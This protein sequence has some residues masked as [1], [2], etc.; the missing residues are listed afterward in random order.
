MVVLKKGVLKMSELICNECGKKLGGVSVFEFEGHTYCES[1]FIDLTVVCECCGDR[2]WRDSA[3]GDSFIVLCPHC[4]A[5]SYT[6]CER[7]S[8][9]ISNDSACYEDDYPYCRECYERILSKPIKSY[10]YK[11][12]PIFYGLGPRYYGLEIEVDCGGESDENAQKLLDYINRD[13][14][15]MYAKHDGSLLR[16]FEFV[17]HPMSLDHHLNEVDYEGLFH[18]AILM[19]Y[20][21]HMTPETAGIHVHINRDAFGKTIEE[22]EKVIARIVFFVENHWNELLKFSRRTEQ[23]MNR[24]S[25]RCGISENTQNTYKKAKERHMGRYVAVNLENDN[26]VEL[27][28]FRSSLRYQTFVAIIQLVDEICHT[29]IYMNDE[30]L[31]GLSWSSFVLGI[32]DDKPEL[33]QYLKSKQLYVNELIEETEEM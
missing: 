22:Q 2:I 27:R 26:T 5:Y 1:C 24:W 8:R 21:G 28:L 4:Y 31:E 18:K 19:G 15:Y 33:I 10:Y 17:T 25:S 7:C 9:L 29:C 23:S 3:E 12:E 16:G 6:H 14:V 11:P 32:K 13:N 30:E 20:R